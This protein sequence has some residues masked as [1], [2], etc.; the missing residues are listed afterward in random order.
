MFQV[1]LFSVNPGEMMGMLA[2]LTGEPSFFTTRT[3]TDVILAVI[4]KANFY[5]YALGLILIRLS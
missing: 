2:V 4:S 1:K 3:K 5:R